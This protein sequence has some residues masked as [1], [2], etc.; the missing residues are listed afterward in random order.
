LALVSLLLAA[1]AAAGPPAVA[2]PVAPDV[3]YAGAWYEQARTP[4]GLTKGC[5]WAITAYGRDEKGRVT[6]RDS[7]HPGRQ[8]AAERSIEGVGDIRDPGVNATVFF[9]YKLG[10]LRPTR[11]YRMIAIDPDNK[12]YISANPGFESVYVFTREVAPPVETVR[13]LARRLRDMGY[14]GDL[15][16]IATPGRDK[17]AE[18]P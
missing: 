16:L 9:R 4:A 8:A 13:G 3:V 7:C 6:V 17:I 18:T 14:K 15:E 12:W 1:A 5:E 2:G 10:P 11:E